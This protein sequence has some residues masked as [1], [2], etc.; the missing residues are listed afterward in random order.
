MGFQEKIERLL[1]SS[2]V[3][4]EPL[5]QRATWELLSRWRSTFASEVQAETGQGTH[6]G[7]EWHAF[8]YGFSA[9]EEGPDGVATVAAALPGPFFL[10]SGWTGVDFGFM[11][12]GA[13][14]DLHSIRMDFIL[15]GDNFDWTLVFTHEL[16]F[17]PYHATA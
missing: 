9:A 10:L 4:F 13:L 11:C 17:G 15:V 3:E 2:G 14:P 8:S 12:N 7:Y 5:A 1:H 16:G 6:L